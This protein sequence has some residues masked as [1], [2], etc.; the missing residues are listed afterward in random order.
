MAKLVSKA[1]GDALLE[2][3]QDMNGIDTVYDEAVELQSVFKDHS[4][5]IQLL[6]HPQIGKEEKIQV[7]EDVFSGQVSAVMMGFLATI[8]NKGRQAD[9]PAI[10]AYFVN[11][12]KEY[13]NIGT[14]YVSSAV[15][16]SPSQKE[17]VKERLLATTR[18]VEFEMDYT[19]DT[20]L[21]G[22]MVIRIGDRVADSSIKT[23]L[24]ELKRDLFN[25]QMA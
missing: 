11:T 12:V 20:S 19:V 23:Q 15:E 8:V 10:F 7:M 5:L 6:N 21:I 14:A 18:Y 17:Q 22:G 4:D 16:L 25:V 1:Y 13:K 3:A 24:Y 9:I 2:A